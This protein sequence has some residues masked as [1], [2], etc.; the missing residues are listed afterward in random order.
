MRT[1]IIRRYFNKFYLKTSKSQVDLKQSGILPT[2]TS[3]S[4][5]CRL[6]IKLVKLF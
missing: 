2:W 5:K 4:I 1:L 6:N 3:T